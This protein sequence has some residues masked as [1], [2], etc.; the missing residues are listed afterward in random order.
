[1]SA[2]HV[3]GP[4]FNNMS[5]Q[6]K[7]SSEDLESRLQHPAFPQPPDPTT[8]VWRYMDLAKFVWLLINKK[9]HF[10]RLDMLDDRHEGTV[11]ASTARGIEKFLKEIG[12]PT[13]WK[14]L[15]ETFQRSRRS[16]FV[17]CWYSGEDESEA[18]WQL[19]CSS[20]HGVA[21]QTTYESLVDSIREAQNTY[22]GC[23]TY[24]DYR[25][26]NFPDANLFYPAMHKRIAFAHEHEV[27]MMIS[28]S[29][30]FSSA[31]KDIPR[32]TTLGWDPENLVETIY[33]NP[34]APDYYFEA[35]QSIIQSIAATL[36]QRLEWSQMRS[37]PFL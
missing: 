18:M 15:S 6:K 23:V 17:N 4:Y 14:Q 25:S 37:V 19:Y 1:V 35:V 28:M 8:K 3:V 7:T 11:P 32:S 31:Q 20:G 5:S 2:E 21:I 16:L 12:S 10:T 26:H 24:V 34:Y 9:L 33:V 22:I 30:H 29:T 27:R 13:R 36:T